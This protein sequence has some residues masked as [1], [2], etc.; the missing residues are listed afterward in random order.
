MNKSYFEQVGEAYRKFGFP[1]AGENKN[2]PHLIEEDLASFRRRFLLEELNEFCSAQENNDLVEIADALVDLVV[3]ALGTAHFYGLPFDKL[4][5]EVHR[6]NLEKTR[7]ETAVQSKRGT[8]WDLQ[9]PEGWKPP[10]LVSIIADY[11]LDI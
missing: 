5:E 3:V 10:D 6:S 7:T 11:I 9:K 1:V 8:A 2:F 4:F